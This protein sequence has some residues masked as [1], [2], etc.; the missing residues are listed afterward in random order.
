MRIEDDVIGAGRLPT[1][2]RGARIADTVVARMRLVGD[3]ISGALARK[4][5]E[6][7]RRS[8]YAELET[9][10]NAAERERDYLREETSGPR[11]VG[12]SPGL[13]RLLDTIDVVAAT[14]AT[15]LIRGESGVGKELFAR[16]AI[17]ERASSAA[18][19]G[20]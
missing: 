3:I 4:R 17:H 1:R 2:A 9:L 10:K 13:K 16:T 7:A 15:V 6:L 20:R 18:A 8:A 14:G 19:S 11:I 5:A 12:A